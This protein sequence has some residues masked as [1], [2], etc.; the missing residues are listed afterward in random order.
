MAMNLP[1]NAGDMSWIPEWGSSP[2]EGNAIHSRILAWEMPWTEEPGGLQ[3]MGCKELDVSYRL[4]NSNVGIL[5]RKN[6]TNVSIFVSPKKQNQW[7]GYMERG[8]YFKESAHMTKRLKSPS[9]ITQQTEHPE[10][11]K[12]PV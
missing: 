12:A 7:D 5:V 2:G 6:K 4:N 11:V 1:A 3:S 8:I 9:R 10:R